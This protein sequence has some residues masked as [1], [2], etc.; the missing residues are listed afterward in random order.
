MNYGVFSRD[1]YYLYYKQCS[2]FDINYTIHYA[3]VWGVNTIYIMHYALLSGV[4]TISTMHYAVFS[5]DGY[6]LY[7]ELCSI[8]ERWILF[9]LWTTQYY[10]GWILFIRWT[11]QYFCRGD[12]NYTIHNAV[13]SGVNTIYTMHYTVFSGDGYYLYYDLCSIFEG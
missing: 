6:Y 11:M 1:E 7:Y 4:D 2:I 12:I 10:R 9:I 5:G 13:F 3:V 8:I